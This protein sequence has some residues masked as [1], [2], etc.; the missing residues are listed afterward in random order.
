[1]LIFYTLKYTEANLSA[2]DVYS[3]LAVKIDTINSEMS[4]LRGVLMS[5]KS[6]LT[7]T[8][9]E[10]TSTKS[11]L[12]S[13][14]AELTF[15]Q[16]KLKSTQ[17]EVD[18]IKS[19]CGLV[20]GISTNT[21]PPI[22]P[23]GN[24]TTCCQVVENAIV[25]MKAEQNQA[26]QDIENLIEKKVTEVNEDIARNSEG[27]VSMGTNIDKLAVDFVS[28]RNITEIQQTEHCQSGYESI[29]KRNT[30]FPYTYTINFK[31]PFR[32]TPAFTIGTSK[33]D[34]YH[35]RNLRLSLVVKEISATQAKVHGSIWSDTIAYGAGFHWMACP[36]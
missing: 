16:T 23:P 31:R 32:N 10:L 2:D 14:K 20:T 29:W 15:T 36:T 8:K 22:T 28:F 4:L 5:T 27:L 25:R 34:F 24:S 6:E 9:A 33:F 13:T 3:M 17:A 7:S 1:M 35:G 21:T 11:E 12:T 18:V 19:Q 30:P 26:K